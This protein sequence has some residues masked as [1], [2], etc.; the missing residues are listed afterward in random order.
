[1]AKQYNRIL[2]I[3]AGGVGAPLA[4]HLGNVASHLAIMDHDTYE[5]HNVHR[6]PIARGQ[7]HMPKVVSLADALKPWVKATVEIIHDKFTED[8]RREIIDGFRPDLIVVAVDNNEARQAIWA[9]N[10]E[11]D[12]LWGANEIWSPQA[13][14]SFK[15]N[16]WNPMDC[17]TPADETPTECGTQTITANLAAASLASLMLAIVISEEKFDTAFISKTAN[18][19]LQLI[20]REEL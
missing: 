6:Q 17:F 19:P 16:P 1:M 18:L 8:N 15:E 12:I 7:M 20:P 13:G 2:L 3:G 5:P 9:L 4:I 11:V 10:K 14:I